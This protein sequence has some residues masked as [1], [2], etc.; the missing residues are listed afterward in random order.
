MSLSALMFPSA[1]SLGIA[2]FSERGTTQL[3]RL[4]AWPLESIWGVPAP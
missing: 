2:T 3:V 1:E 4:E